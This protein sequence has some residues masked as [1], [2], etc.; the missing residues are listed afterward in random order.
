MSQELTQELT[1][2]VSG[3]QMNEQDMG[4][5]HLDQSSEPHLVEVAAYQTDSRY[6]L[7]RLKGIGWEPM[8]ENEFRLRVRQVFPEI[9]FD[10]PEQVHWADRPGEWP[11]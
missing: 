9:D 2:Y 3:E 4:G 7:V 5:D 6:R 10:D 11:R 8:G 1:E